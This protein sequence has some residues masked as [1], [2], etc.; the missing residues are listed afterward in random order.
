[1]KQKTI[2][3]FLE[4]ELRTFQFADNHRSIPDMVDSFKPS[5]RKVLYTALSE[6]LRG[7]D[8][9]EKLS[10]F[11]GSV[12]KSTSYHHG[13]T[14]LYQAVIGMTQDYVGSNNINLF[15][16]CGQFGTRRCGG[17]DSAAPRYIFIYLNP[18]VDLIYIKE[19]NPIL[20][21]LDD[22][23]KTIEPIRFYPIIPMTLT[24]GGE[25][26]G[27]GW[28]TKIPQ[29]NPLDLI[30]WIE[31]KLA[32]KKWKSKLKLW[33]KGFIGDIKQI[34]EYQ[35]CVSGII[36][37]VNTTR[38]DVMEIPV[39]MST[40]KYV[41]I[42]EKLSEEGVI[43]SYKV[44]TDS[45]DGNTP[46]F[47]VQFTRENLKILDTDEKLL[48]CL[49][50]NSTIST[51]NMHTI[52]DGKIRKYDNPEELCEAFYSKRL[53]MYVKRK[54][55]QVN[56]MT[57]ENNRLKEIA[58]FLGLILDEK[59]IIQKRKKDDIINDIKTNSFE[60]INDSYDYLLNMPLWNLTKE[61]WDN[62]N[63]T[64]KKKEDELKKLIETSIEEM[65]TKDLTNLKKKLIELG[66]K[67]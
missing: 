42:L 9:Q 43:R 26:I 21:Y 22:E 12:Q 19:D 18:I 51:S 36:N 23:G 40:E 55:Y 16:P 39:D 52:T 2:E 48:A 63:E 6:N 31:T 66:Y 8:K 59:L 44:L 34:T 1:M 11:A 57:F 47:E 65:W 10:T 13:E 5:T 30:E 17:N 3:S 62:I 27:T 56:Q 61:K 67:K 4:N 46:T 54:E 15:I 28:S 58:R 24:N 37:R 49:K 32:G 14:S 7:E 20:E 35:W 45:S 29:Y 25:G 64:V 41:S 33:Y 60:T 53:E 38:I 50:L